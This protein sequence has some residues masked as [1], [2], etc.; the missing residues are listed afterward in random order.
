MASIESFEEIE[1]WKSA[2]KLTNEIYVVTKAVPFSHDYGLRDQIRRAAA[3]S[4]MSNISEGFEGQT[5]KTFLRYLIYSEGFR[6]RSAC[7]GLYR[8]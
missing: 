3:V 6:G 2:R 5:D 8:S 4:I 1:A 7:P